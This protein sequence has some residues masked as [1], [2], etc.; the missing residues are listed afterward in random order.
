[1]K[2]VGKIDSRAIEIC[3]RGLR[4]FLP[5]DRGNAVMTPKPSFLPQALAPIRRG[6]DETGQFKQDVHNGGSLR[7][8]GPDRGGR[9]EV[10]Q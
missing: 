7:R 8:V 5:G 10:M 9:W 3:T 1:M 2:G 6:E 4:S